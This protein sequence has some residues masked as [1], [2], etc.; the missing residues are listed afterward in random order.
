[1]AHSVGLQTYH[2]RHRTIML[3]QFDKC[4]LSQKFINQLMTELASGDD[5]IAMRC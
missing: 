2:G 3:L 4:E 1:M 5:V